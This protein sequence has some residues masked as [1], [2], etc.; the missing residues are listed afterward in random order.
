MAGKRR[1]G[2]DWTK[3]KSQPV[4]PGEPRVVRVVKDGQEHVAAYVGNPDGATEKERNL[5]EYVDKDGETV[6][7]NLSTFLHHYKCTNCSPWQ[8]VELKVF[9]A[10]G[11]F[12]WVKIGNPTLGIKIEQPQQGTRKKKSPLPVP[13]LP[14]NMN[15]RPP[16]AAA[17]RSKT[18]SP[19]DEEPAAAARSKTLSPSDEP[20]AAAAYKP[21]PAAAAAHKPPP[22]AAAHKPPQAAAAAAAAAANRPKQMPNNSDMI[23]KNEAD[24]ATLYKESTKS[25]RELKLSYEKYTDAL[26]AKL[27]ARQKLQIECEEQL[28]KYRERVHKLKDTEG[29]QKRKFEEQL[30]LEKEGL[31]KQI[32]SLRRRNHECEDQ[33][34]N[35]KQRRHQDQ[36]QTRKLRFTKDE[37]YKKLER[38]FNKTMKRHEKREQELVEQLDD[39]LDTKKGIWTEYTTGVGR[40]YYV[41]SRTNQTVWNL[42]PNAR[43]ITDEERKERKE[44]MQEQARKPAAAAAA[45]AT[46]TSSPAQR[47]SSSTPND[48]SSSDGEE[49]IIEEGSAAPAAAS[50]TASAASLSTALES[51]SESVSKQ[52]EI[53]KKK[54]IE[55]LEELKKKLSI[56]EKNIKNNPYLLYIPNYKPIIENEL[57]SLKTKIKTVEAE[58][59][60]DLQTLVEQ[61]RQQANE[62]QPLQSVQQNDDSSGD[63]EILEEG[64]AGPSREEIL[65]QRAEEQRRRQ[66]LDERNRQRQQMARR[67]AEQSRLF[68]GIQKGSK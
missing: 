52:F 67:N 44:R 62:A 46:A 9:N 47:K 29:E 8:S 13:P 3:F 14:R 45:V 18:L 60:Q 10:N 55:E 58:L 36:I 65:A 53:R 2:Y 21:P 28:K 25:L 37:A 40:P 19:S 38:N 54:K 32:A 26:I 16:A 23:R 5:F 48:D 61:E 22:A 57:N 15:H 66:Q 30:K 50:A 6:R 4:R 31:Q 59:R 39:C 33:L 35:E 64:Y 49:I 11:E 1:F 51:V 12:L 34:R 56:K 43:V 63:E 42:P 27:S 17:P 20:P 41:N 24:I 68:R 7:T